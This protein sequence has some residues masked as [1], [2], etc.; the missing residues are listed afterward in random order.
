MKCATVI[1]LFRLI[2][3]PIA[4]ALSG[5]ASGTHDAARTRS[6]ATAAGAVA[7]A[8]LGAGVGALTTKDKGRGALAGAGV[9]AVAGAF[10]GAAA[11]DAT[12][13]KKAAY[14]GREDALSRQIA[15]VERQATER[16]GVNASLRLTV[17]REQQRLA[18]LKASGPAENP[19]GWSDLRKTAAG[20][21]AA[22]DRRARSWQETIDA[23]KAFVRKYHGDARGT[24]F[25][26][27]LSSLDAE[28][29]ELLRQRGQLEVIAAGPRK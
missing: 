27:S 28:R 21:I 16:R 17:A 8:A 2:L 18:V 29:T 23:H 20:E 25:E 26:N 3:L 4:I 14:I 24:Q 15:L 13:K 12:V 10:A 7:G 9:G 22:I 5:C 6:E 19:A 1:Q 11:G